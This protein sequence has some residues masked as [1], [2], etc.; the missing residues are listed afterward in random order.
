MKKFLLA[1]FIAFGVNSFVPAFSACQLTANTVQENDQIDALVERLLVQTKIFDQLDAM[2]NA[3][4]APYMQEANSLPEEQVAIIKRFI[5]RSSDYIKS[6]DF[7]DAFKNI[8]KKHF[9]VCEVH[10]L[11][12][13][14]ESAAGKKFI[15]MTP[16]VMNE[17]IS[18]ITPIIQNMTN[19]MIL[20]LQELQTKDVQMQ[21]Q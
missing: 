2:I 4:L 14:Y 6:A 11:V 5:N 8:Y 19:D 20:E 18:L 17:A 1:A 7:I 3:S 15:A 21:V 10:A 12:E 9:T 16:Q 13:F